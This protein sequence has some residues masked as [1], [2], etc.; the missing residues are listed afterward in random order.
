MKVAIYLSTS[1][2]AFHTCLLFTTSGLIIPYYSDHWVNITNIQHIHW[3]E[4]NEMCIHWIMENQHPKITNKYLLL[5]LNYPHLEL[6]RPVL[7]TFFE[8]HKSHDFCVWKHFKFCK[9][10]WS[11]PYSQINNPWDIDIFRRGAFI[12]LSKVKWPENRYTLYIVAIKI[13]RYYHDCKC[14]LWLTS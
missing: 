7:A 12:I 4:T 5:I 3:P 6:C 13:Y 1:D 10:L 11:I 9:I 2:L 14:R 8:L